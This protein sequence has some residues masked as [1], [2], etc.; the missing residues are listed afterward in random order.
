MDARFSPIRPSPIPGMAT[1]WGR[2][3]IRRAPLASVTRLFTIHTAGDGL[4]SPSV[5]L[6]HAPV[7]LELPDV[8]HRAHRIRNLVRVQSDQG[9]GWMVS[10]CVPAA[11]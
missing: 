4:R 3:P 2:V 1:V 9:L 7:H 10:R 11:L 8:P 6:G 5:T